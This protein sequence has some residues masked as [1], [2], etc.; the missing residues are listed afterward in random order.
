MPS[1]S[2]TRRQPWPR[3][4]WDWTRRPP[5]WA[6]LHP[7]RGRGRSRGR[8]R[9]PGAKSCGEASWV[10]NQV[11]RRSASRA[12]PSV[13]YASVKRPPT[14]FVREPV[15][16]NGFSTVVGGA[17][18]PFHT[19]LS[20][21]YCGAGP[22]FTAEAAEAAAVP[23]RRPRKHNPRVDF[24]DVPASANLPFTRFPQT[25]EGYANLPT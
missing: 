6:G 19:P 16:E 15:P 23:G 5:F 1:P 3:Q 8:H 7:R 22:F 4:P 9:P 17:R 12:E 24:A 2:E 21:I 10:R 18:V 13:E 11:L 25:A 20:P 14:A